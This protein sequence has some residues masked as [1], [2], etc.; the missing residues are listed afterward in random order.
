MWTCGTPAS[1]SHRD[2]FLSGPPT[3]MRATLLAEGF[4]L[5][6]AQARTIFSA[7]S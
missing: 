3:V 2:H 6:L 5:P 7:A 4:R 1:G